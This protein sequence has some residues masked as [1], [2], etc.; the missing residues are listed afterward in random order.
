MWWPLGGQQLDAACVP[1]RLADLSSYCRSVRL[2]W[3]NDT[4]LPPGLRFIKCICRHNPTTLLDCLLHATLP[5]P[6]PP[7]SYFLLF[8]GVFLYY[9]TVF[10]LKTDLAEQQ[11]GWVKP[12]HKLSSMPSSYGR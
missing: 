10:G 3:F 4:L 8:S 7:C 6:L 12:V 5:C 1:S 2:T 11:V 9:S